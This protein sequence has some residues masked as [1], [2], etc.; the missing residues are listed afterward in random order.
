MSNLFKNNTRFSSLF[1]NDTPGKT[2]NTINNNKTLKNKE[3]NGFNEN[4]NLKNNKSLNQNNISEQNT[5]NFISKE[6]KEESKNIKILKEFNINDFPELNP[7]K[8]EFKINN[9]IDFLSIIKTR[10]NEE[11]KENEE[12]EEDIDEDY[13]NLKPGWTLL[14]RDKTTCKT[15]IKH[16]PIY[17]N[18]NE[19]IINKVFD[20]TEQEI[21][22]D[23]FKR[24][25]ELYEERTNEYIELWGYD[26]WEKRFRFPNYD[27]NYFDKLDEKYAEEMEES[28]ETEESEDDMYY[29]DE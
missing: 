29:N 10:E 2:Y 17:N 5:N 25:A 6:K 20:K 1:E 4:R 12:N 11:N 22:Y 8:K 18:I 13:I 27:Y 14:R 3:T 26:E 21:T 9:K 23:I 15:I 24:L 19:T 7:I 16:K 28:E